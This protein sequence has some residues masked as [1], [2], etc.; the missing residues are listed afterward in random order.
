[1]KHRTEMTSIQNQAYKHARAQYPS[2]LMSKDGHLKKPLV[3]CNGD[4]AENLMT[5]MHKQ[6]KR[7]H[8][9]DFFQ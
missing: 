9:F 5:D 4:A 7:K 8:F 1:M 3:S 2:Q 6:L